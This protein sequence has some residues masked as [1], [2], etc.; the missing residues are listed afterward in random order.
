MDNDLL[1][2]FL[3]E[4]TDDLNS[5]GTLETIQLIIENLMDAFLYQ[6]QGFKFVDEKPGL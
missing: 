4:L 5:L 3:D 6:V 2:P 1:T